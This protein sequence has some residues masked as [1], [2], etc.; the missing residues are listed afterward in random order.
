MLG[1]VGPV[2][3]AAVGAGVALDMPAAPEDMARATVEPRPS[4]V[5]ALGRA[6]VAASAR[7]ER[8]LS[9]KA[10]RLPLQ[11]VQ[12]RAVQS[13]A[14]PVRADLTT[15]AM[16]WAPASSSRA[17]SPSPLRPPAARR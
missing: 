1:P 9:S 12:S 13:P 11:A 7:V 4:A 2:A 3:S 17:I 8:Y 15:A 14:G 10:A 6:E 5:A 16:A